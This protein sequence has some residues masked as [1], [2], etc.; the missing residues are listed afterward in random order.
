[1]TSSTS[2]LFHRFGSTLILAAAL[3]FVVLPIIAIG[4]EVLR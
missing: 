3:A 2:A 1:M 4:A